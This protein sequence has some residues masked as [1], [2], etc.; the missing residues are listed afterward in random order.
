MNGINEA[1]SKKAYRELCSTHTSISLFSKDW[2]F[3]SVCDNGER[4]DAVI[5]KKS[6]V[7]IAALPYVMKKKGPFNIQTMPKLTQNFQ[8]WIN[9]PDG[10]KDQDIIDFEVSAVSG[11]VSLLP[12]SHFVS[13]NV[14][15]K[16]SNL[17]PF[18]W[19]GFSESALYTYVVDDLSD[20]PEV[21][22]RFDGSM[23]N[24]VRKAE[25]LV[26]TKFTDDI[27]VFYEINKKTF[28]RQGLE[29]PYTFNFLE[30]HDKALKE[31]KSRQIFLA[32][33]DLGR[34]HSALYLTWDSHSSY[35]HMVGEDPELR[36]SG[37]GIKLIWDAIQFTRNELGLNCFDFEGSMIKSVENVRRNCGGQQRVYSNLTRCDSKI[38]MALVGLRN[39]LR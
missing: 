21:F 19:A 34:A 39:I 3:D 14:N 7:V 35:V 32:V 9:Y 29:I 27:S 20:L 17:I 8:I 26:A 12:K 11:I 6:G 30:K 10:I 16:L 2:W 38:L 1:D 23:R 31:R 24:K 18:H 22:S 13:F 33:D 36:S 28:T 4:W 5:Y 25:K 37:A 15:Y